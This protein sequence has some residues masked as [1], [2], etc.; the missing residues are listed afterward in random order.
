M[1]ILN[2]L[3]FDPQIFVIQIV[4][5]IAL[6][7]TMNH[8]FWKPMLK[9][10]AG[11]DQSIK[12]AYKSVEDTRHEMER[13][14][15]D[16]QA[17][18]AQIE[19]DARSRIQAAIREAQTERERLLAEARAQADAAIKQ[20]AAD[21]EREKNEAL[22]ALRDRMT[23]MALAAVGKALGSAA[24]PTTLRQ[25]IETHIAASVPARN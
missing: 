11:R 1:Q 5:F 15:T 19:A 12:D 6:W 2:S 13:L 4:L 21:M 20:G 10:L 9:H 18:I 8:L 23:Q 22:A 14:R 17:R 24:E 16:Y 7:I 3:N 25:S